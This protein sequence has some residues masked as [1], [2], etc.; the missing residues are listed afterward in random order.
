[1]ASTGDMGHHFPAV[2]SLFL[3]G[4]QLSLK[5]CSEDHPYLDIPTQ[6]AYGWKID[7]NQKFEH[8]WTE[9]DILLQGFIDTM[10]ENAIDEEN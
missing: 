7:E 4:S 10:S 1:M 9:G 3:S 6:P 8:D 5:T 2:L